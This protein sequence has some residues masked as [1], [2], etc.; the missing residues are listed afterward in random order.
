MN[1]RVPLADTVSI[2]GWL[3][4]SRYFRDFLARALGRRLVIASGQN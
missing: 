4:R 1:D 3:T 2:D